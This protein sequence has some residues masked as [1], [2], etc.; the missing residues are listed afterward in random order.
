MRLRERG[1]EKIDISNLCQIREG[2]RDL[3]S[4]LDPSYSFVQLNLN[5][6]CYVMTYMSP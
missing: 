4:V 5:L 2:E 1:C 3:F 6:V